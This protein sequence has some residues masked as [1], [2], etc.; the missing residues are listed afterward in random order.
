MS[1]RGKILLVG[2]GPGDL[3]QM[4]GRAQAAIAA[5]EVVIGYRT[6]LRSIAPLL[7]GKTVVA[8]DMAEEMARCREAVARAEAG[9]VVALVS[10]GD[11]GIFGMAGPLYEHLLE[12]AWTPETGIEV[13]VVPGVTAASACASL[14]GAPLTHDFCAISLSDLL[15]PWSVIAARLEAAARADFVTVLYNPQSRRRTDQMREAQAILL[16]HRPSDTPLAIVHAAYRPRQSVELTTLER[17]L[18]HDVGM[19]STLIVGNSSSIAQAGVM[20]TPRGYRRKY[21]DLDAGVKPGES[22]RHSL[23]SGFAGWRHALIEHAGRHGIAATARMLGAPPTR[24]L[25]ALIE[26]PASPLGVVRAPNPTTLF[27]QALHWPNALV[28]L[29]LTQS[30]ATAL[31]AILELSDA[32]QR[33]GPGADGAPATL[34]GPGWRLELP[35][36]AVVSAYQ[37]SDHHQIAA[38]FQSASGETLLRIERPR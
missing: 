8:R 10:S 12:R 16:R 18:E 20:V 38:W 25:E 17:L 37:V 22:P 6:Y 23:S 15:T 36:T 26:S 7:T 30:P 3:E 35:W 34:S 24:I 19:I 2:L 32:V 1:R 4:T 14:V 5:A 33:Q 11:V 9:Q 31:E 27:E 29:N 13:E 21:D 28:H